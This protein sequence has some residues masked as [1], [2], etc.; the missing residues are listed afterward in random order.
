MQNK[1]KAAES[2]TKAGFSLRAI[3]DGTWSQ[4]QRKLHAQKMKE[5]YG[6]ASTETVE[7]TPTVASPLAVSN[8]VE[9]TSSSFVPVSAPKRRKLEEDQSE[10]GT[11]RAR[12]TPTD[13]GVTRSHHDENMMDVDEGEEEISDYEP[14]QIDLFSEKS[15]FSDFGLE[16][17]LLHNLTENMKLERPTEVQAQSW[18]HL[19]TASPHDAMI[20]APTGSGKTL[21]YVIPIVQALITS[22]A[23]VG[24]AD[25]TRA[26]IIAPTREL[27]LQIYEVLRKVLRP[28]PHV[29]PGAIMGGEKRKSEKARL[30]KGVG[31]LVSTPGRL[32]D[33]LRN[34]NSFQLPNLSWLVFD[35]ADRLLDM[36]F[37][38][39]VRQILEML[40][41]K[42]ASP[43]DRLISVLCSATLND[44]V[45]RLVDLALQDPVFVNVTVKDTHANKK[46]LPASSQ[47]GE[48]GD[49]SE[50][51]EDDDLE[52][53]PAGENDDDDDPNA[54]D[55]ARQLGDR[56]AADEELERAHAIPPQLRQ[57]FTVCHAKRKLVT[58]ATFLRWKL[59]ADQKA[60]ILVFLSNCDSVEYLYAL[61]STVE[62]PKASARR[63]RH[64]NNDEEDDSEPLLPCN[65]FKLHGNLSQQVRSATFA[66]FG[67]ADKGIM[68]ATDV[69]ARGV[70]IPNISWI[71]QYDVP[72][73]PAAYVHRI[74]R[75]ARIGA[76]GDALLMIV[77]SEKP[78]VDILRARKHMNMNEVSSES[79]LSHLKTNMEDPKRRPDVARE[80]SNLQHLMEQIVGSQAHKDFK[81]MAVRAYQSFLRSYATHSKA[82]KHIFHIKN[83]HLGHLARNFALVDP[84]S[85]FKE[86][87]EAEE[88]TSGAKKLK[89]GKGRNLKVYRTDSPGDVLPGIGSFSSKF[90]GK[91]ASAKPRT[92]QRRFAHRADASSEFSSGI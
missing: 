78:Y 24:R 58:L 54:S 27:C 20:K 77:E 68:F 76:A 66:T 41:K 49:S 32:L 43:G 52:V 36:G 12:A 15:A 85:K 81:M 50:S 38:Q 39:D 7:A 42:S 26:V 72:A 57:H 90:L 3:R 30:R 29:V 34:T 16:S 28:F 91:G 40:S 19:L 88:A 65:L 17:H 4:Q 92:L 62:L 60:K 61:F 35:E 82:T 44:N 33:H 31:V 69:V 47:S 37:E 14:P 89:D 18:Q 5:K 8:A 25:G 51:N 46:D 59:Q 75:T 10:Q 80:C 45:G 71:V 86:M 11:P 73:D 48:S 63:R 83:I 56:D 21:A 13:A 1:S 67:K 87:L 53:V 74:G 84:P 64:N 79:I 2:Q 6:A 9:S 70:D 23:R 22:A 55:E